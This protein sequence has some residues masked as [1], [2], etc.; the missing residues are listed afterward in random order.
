MH[1]FGKLEN[2]LRALDTLAETYLS[3]ILTL[4]VL[5]SKIENSK[6]GERLKSKVKVFSPDD[7]F[8]GVRLSK[9]HIPSRD[10]ASGSCKK[11]SEEVRDL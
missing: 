5:F 3:H 8:R 9:A 10:R 4:A 1:H 11:K 7:V 6:S 2:S